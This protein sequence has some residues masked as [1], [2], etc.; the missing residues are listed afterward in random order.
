MYDVFQGNGPSSSQPDTIFV[1]QSIVGKWSVG[2]EI[3]IT[4][5]TLVWNA[6][7][8]RRIQSISTFFASMTGNVALTLN[9]TILRPTTLKESADFAVEVALLSRNIVFQGGPD[10]VTDHGGHFMVMNTPAVVQTIEGVEFRNFGQQGELGRYPIHFHYC[11]DVPGSVVSKNTIRESNQRCVVVHGTNKLRV[12]ENVAFDTKGHCYMTEDGIET[13]NEFLYN[14]GAATGIPLKI[15][16]NDGTN[17]NETDFQPSTFWITN[18]TNVFVGNVAAGSEHTG[19][20]F[21]PKTRGI[22]LYLYPNY[23]PM[24]APLSEFRDN[25]AHSNTGGNL[26]C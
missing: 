9:E 18:P 24:Y 3:L 4:P 10:A 25:V 12:Q 22:R 21:E 20:W 19:F 26:V 5:H 13:G 15:I 11:S 16:P 17:G 14:L 7:Q 6:V 2:A 23:D 8:V 1:P